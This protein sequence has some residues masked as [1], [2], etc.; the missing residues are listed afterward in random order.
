M[1]LPGEN[2]NSFLQ[3]TEELHRKAVLTAGRKKLT[4]KEI[5]H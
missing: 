1:E 4:T 5:M 3:Q 2:C